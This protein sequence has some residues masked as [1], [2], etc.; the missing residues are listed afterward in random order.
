MKPWHVIAIIVVLFGGYFTG[1]LNPSAS[2]YILK[3][4]ATIPGVVTGTATTA[5][6]AKVGPLAVTFTLK[7]QNG[8]F[9][10]SVYTADIYK[11]SST[12]GKWVMMG[13]HTA[14]ATGLVTSAASYYEEDELYVNVNLRA[15]F[16]GDYW[17]K[18]KVDKW[19]GDPIT[20]LSITTVPSYGRPVEKGSI[21]TYGTV[22]RAAYLNVLL[23]NQASTA[24]SANAPMH[25]GPATPLSAAA[26][27]TNFQGYFYLQVSTQA[28]QAFGGKY[29][30]PATDQGHTARTLTSIC[31]VELNTTLVVFDLT[32]G[33]DSNQWEAATPANATGKRIYIEVPLVETRDTFPV[34]KMV[35]LYM[36]L[37]GVAAGTAAGAGG[38]S[39]RIGWID[40]QTLTDA[41]NGVAFST[42]GANIGLSRNFGRTFY[43]YNTA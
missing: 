15:N 41:K 13:H 31:F 6:A 7:C 24:I 4:G 37:A 33:V 29:D 19:V 43:V 16:I 40:Q 38:L 36:N 21:S 42:S 14:A 17:T 39:I 30:V 26:G 8:T 27:L 3:P 28:W 5:P 12:L 25:S 10:A 22:V 1:Y 34:N 32:K 23:Y 9:L 35:Y 2:N 11:Y 20:T 18:V